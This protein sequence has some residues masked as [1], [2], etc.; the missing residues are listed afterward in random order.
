M[1]FSS[2]DNHDFLVSDMLRFALVSKLNNTGV[3]LP[4]GKF[5]MPIGL[6]RKPEGVFRMNRNDAST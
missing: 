5:L 3:N 4:N 6:L 2:V 1:D